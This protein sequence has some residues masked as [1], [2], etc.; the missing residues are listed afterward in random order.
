MSIIVT[1][2]KLDVNGNIAHSNVN[3]IIGAIKAGRANE[4]ATSKDSQ[5]LLT[6][7][8]KVVTRVDVNGTTFVM[9]TVSVEDNNDT[10]NYTVTVKV[11]GND[12]PTATANGTVTVPVN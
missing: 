11:S 1:T 5:T 12:K 2:P 3:N 10:R 9:S 7:A 4:F 8:N 6:K